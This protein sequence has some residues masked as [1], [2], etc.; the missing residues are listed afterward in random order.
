MSVDAVEPARRVDDP[1]VDEPLGRPAEQLGVGIGADAAHHL[2]H[3]VLGRD[4]LAVHVHLP[5]GF[6]SSDSMASG[7]WLTRGVPRPPRAVDPP[8]AP[9]LE[10]EL[11]AL[12]LDALESGARIERARL[13]G[14]E[15]AGARARGVV[16]EEA[17]LV[18]ADLSGARLPGLRLADVA[19]ER[20]NLANTAAPDLSLQRVAVSGARLTGAQWTR[21]TITDAVFRDCRIDLATFAGTTFER[22][23]FDGCLLAQADFRDALWRSV[24]FDRCDLTEADLAGVRVDRCELS[25]CML[26]GLFGIERL[27]GAAMPWADI[28]GH[29]EL[30][31]AALGIRVLEPGDAR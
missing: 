24:R 30:L 2:R 13:E 5:V 21:G 6:G 16:L 31:A 18:G 4:R 20:G 22:V 17:R 1:H 27:R 15:L 11:E 19:V 29:A 10:E 3:L 25:G 26:A 7:V 9:R 12:A 23:A 14:V 8:A 28:V